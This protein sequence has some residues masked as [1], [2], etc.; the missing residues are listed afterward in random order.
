MWR[1]DESNYTGNYLFLKNNYELIR[2][3]NLKLFGKCLDT[4]LSLAQ[5][6]LF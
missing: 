1:V 6:L 2:C 5:T 3:G 4:P